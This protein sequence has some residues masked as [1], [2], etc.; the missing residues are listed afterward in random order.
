MANEAQ[1]RASLNVKIGNLD[2]RSS[3]TS[4]NATASVAKGP[5]PGGLTISTLGENIDLSEL[6]TPGLCRIHNLSPTYYVQYGIYDV[7][8]GEFFPL[9]ELLPGEFTI[10]RLSRVLGRQ[11][12]GTGTGVTGQ[13]SL[14]LRSIDGECNVV[15]DAFEGA[16]S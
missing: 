1:I 10:F 12:I 9:G 14:R 16:S 11:Y 13:T 7:T 4:F 6:T 5:T 15:V 8:L 2:Y 3:P